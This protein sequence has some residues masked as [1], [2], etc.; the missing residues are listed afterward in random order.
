MHDGKYPPIYAVSVI[1]SRSAP[2]STSSTNLPATLSY[3]EF[4][5]QFFSELDY[6]LERKNLETVYQSSL[7]PLSPYIKNG[8]VVPEVYG[9]FCSGRVLTMGYFPGPK[10]EIE[11]KRQLE[12]LGVDVK[13]SIGDVVR[14]AAKEASRPAE[15]SGGGDADVARNETT[16]QRSY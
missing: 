10:F 2:T 11:A 16:L 1:S 3:D 13:R 8:V 12:A 9:E 5:R 6:T 7:D 4:S 15:S 14:H